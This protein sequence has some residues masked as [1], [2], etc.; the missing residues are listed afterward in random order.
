MVVD[1]ED[2][3]LVTTL[4]G[5]NG[6]KAALAPQSLFLLQRQ[7]FSYVASTKASSYLS[8]Q[9]FV[10]ALQEIYSKDR[11]GLMFSPFL[12]SRECIWDLIH[13]Y[14]IHVKVINYYCV[15]LSFVVITNIF[16]FFNS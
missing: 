14:T 12:Q 13:L 6:S 4:H 5:S 7:A 10:Y 9:E 8:V 1:D 16:Y 15:V 3:E 11:Y 2:Q